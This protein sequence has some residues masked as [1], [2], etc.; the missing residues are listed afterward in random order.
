MKNKTNEALVFSSPVKGW[1]RVFDLAVRVFVSTFSAMAVCFVY[2]DAFGIKLYYQKAVTILLA[3]VGFAFFWQLI[4]ASRKK[5]A[6]ALVILV[7]EAVLFPHGDIVGDAAYL[8]NRIMETIAAKGFVTLPTVMSRSQFPEYGAVYI[9]AFVSVLVFSVSVRKRVSVSACLIYMA[10]V[11]SPVLVYN[12]ADVGRG[13]VMTVCAV[14]M[15]AAMGISERKSDVPIRSGHAA[16]GALVLSLV[17]SLIVSATVSGAFGDIPLIAEKIDDIRTKFVG[18]LSVDIGGSDGTGGSKEDTEVRDTTATKRKYKNVRVFSCYADAAHPIYLRNW[19]GSVYTDGKWRST[20]MELIFSSTVMAADR[21]LADEYNSVYSTALGVENASEMLG[22]RRENVRIVLDSV[23]SLLPIPRMMVTGLSFDEDDVYAEMAGEGMFRP[24]EGFHAGSS[25]EMTAVVPAYRSGDAEKFM[26]IFAEFYYGETSSPKSSVHTVPIPVTIR[27][28]SESDTYDRQIVSDVIRKM[29]GSP[30][31]KEY[32]DVEYFDVDKPYS[33]AYGVDDGQWYYISEETR[34][35]N[36]DGIVKAVC[37]YLARNYSYT[38]SPATPTVS[39]PLEEFLNVSGEGYCVQFA[40]AATLILRELGFEAR[41]A[42][43]YAASDFKPT[44]DGKYVCYVKDSDAHAWTEVWIDGIGWMPYEATPPYNDVMSHTVPNPDG[45]DVTEPIPDD[46]DG[47]ETDTSDAVTELPEDTDARTEPPTPSTTDGITGTEDGRSLLPLLI[48]AGAVIVVTVA[49]IAI[50]KRSENKTKK[51]CSI[52]RRA[53]NCGNIPSAELQALAA[54]VGT[55]LLSLL[56]AYGVKRGECEMPT[57]FGKR[58]DKA[59][60]HL[61]PPVA[62]SRCVEALSALAYGGAVTPDGV[63]D[64][65]LL[66]S[67]LLENA[68]DRLGTADYIVKRYIFAE[69]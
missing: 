7:L 12:L 62:P 64:C 56:S 2:M 46:T 50:L 45:T 43:G 5:T 51:R 11:F 61:S 17:L 34:K 41:Y 27:L 39:D 25:Y 32:F 36:A 35:L 58:A 31:L 3:T 30:E 10:F 42:E 63:R 68:K 6:A 4:F 33:T 67:F 40:T 23:P 15:L 49:V 1:E 9:I 18:I 53:E 16:L 28:H 54:S 38:L 65:A 57:E 44:A 59:L 60:A 52:L 24:K 14:A 21:C 26:R 19:V 22:L 66:T 20:W 55:E 29:A 69:I 37:K 13:T 47:G 8:W 48:A